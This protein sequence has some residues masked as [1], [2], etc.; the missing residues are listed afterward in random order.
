MIFHRRF[1]CR[2]GESMDILEDDMYTNL[3][4]Q[5]S[6]TV[7]IP[8]R[9]SQDHVVDGQGKRMIEFCLSTGLVIGNGRLYI[10]LGR[11][12]NTFHA[13]NGSRV[14][15]YLLLSPR[16]LHYVSHV[17]LPNQLNFQIILG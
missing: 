6:N 1:N 10:D 13:F 16:D 2:T 8:P 5:L 15:D 3:N 7:N 9:V 14:V 17:V 12:D 4:N 11:G